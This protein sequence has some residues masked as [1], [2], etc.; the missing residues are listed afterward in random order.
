MMP[1][2]VKARQGCSK[3]WLDGFAPDVC[4]LQIDSTPEPLIVHI[5]N[6][7]MALLGAIILLCLARL[8]G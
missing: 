4:I 1:G 5:R 3:P 6:P 8:D 2:V 7:N